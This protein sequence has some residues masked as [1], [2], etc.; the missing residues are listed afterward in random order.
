MGKSSKAMYVGG[1]SGSKSAFAKALHAVRLKKGVQHAQGSGIK[2]SS[3]QRHSRGKANKAKVPT[4]CSPG[5][6]YDI[7]DGLDDHR[8]GLLRQTGF[9][10][11]TKLNIFKTN[12]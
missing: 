8:L 4:R 9:E 10:G 7:F 11:L 5:I 12:K 6:I 3:A 2:R 1:N